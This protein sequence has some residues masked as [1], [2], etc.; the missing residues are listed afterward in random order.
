L[1]QFA[2]DGQS[3]LKWQHLIAEAVRSQRG[4]YPVTA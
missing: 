4:S 3:A 1:S 2:F